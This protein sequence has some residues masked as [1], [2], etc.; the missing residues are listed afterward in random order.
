MTARQTIAAGQLLLAL[1]LFSSQAAGQRSEDKAMADALFD[2]GKRL[3]AAGDHKAACPKFKASFDLLPRLGVRLNLADCYDKAGMTASAWAEFRAAA[4]VAENEGDRREKFAKQ[5]VADLEPRLSRLIVRPA[6][7]SEIPGLEVKR[8]G[9]TVVP[10]S[11]DLAIPV[12]PGIHSLEASAP[13]RTSWRQQVRVIGAGVVVTVEVPMLAMPLPAADDRRAP[14]STPPGATTAAAAGQSRPP[15]AE[16]EKPTT[17]A[18]PPTSETAPAGAASAATPAV[19]AAAATSSAEPGV[20]AS[21]A[22]RQ[23]ENEPAPAASEQPPA[24][25]DSSPDVTASATAG[26]RRGRGRR[27]LGASMGVAGALAIGAGA[28]FGMTAKTKWDD[29]R[30]YCNEENECTPGSPGPTLI[31]E[32][33]SAGNI[34]TGAFAAGAAL[35]VTGLIL[36]WTAPPAS[37]PA[38]ARL[39]AKLSLRVLPPVSIGS[40]AV[41]AIGGDF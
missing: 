10:A 3:T 38:E 36:Y 33:Q 22:A 12:D 5:R 16:A 8:D 35:A 24:A 4:T 15:A 31:D 37:S 7:D 1:L 11:F 28:Y 23:P 21:D 34:A 13:G 29:S 39:S 9:V 25:N 41:F 6:F 40:S 27:I 32:A 18:R 30:E 26:P 2:E 14:A 17:A 20:P 19:T